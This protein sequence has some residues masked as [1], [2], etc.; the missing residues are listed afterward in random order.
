MAF[1]PNN[2]DTNKQ[3]K[4]GLN[5]RYTYT[6][7]LVDVTGTG[8]WT[9]LFCITRVATKQYSYVGLTYSEANTLKTTKTTKYTRASKGWRLTGD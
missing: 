7:K 1:D 8:V 9:P 2:P 5:I 6:S 4:V 3:T